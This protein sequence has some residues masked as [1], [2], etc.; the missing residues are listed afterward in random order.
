MNNIINK[1]VLVILLSFSIISCT[2][3]EETSDNGWP[4]E[5]TLGFAADDNLTDYN[6][7][8]G[9]LGDYI[10]DQLGLKKVHLKRSSEYAAVIEAMK[11]GKVDIA[12]LGGLSYILAHEKTG[13][14]AIVRRALTDTIDNFTSSVLLTHPNAKYKTIE[15]IKTNAGEL[16]L[17]FGDP[18]STSGHLFPRNYLNSVGI[19]PEKDF[20]EVIFTNSHTTSVFSIK[21]ESLDLAWTYRLAL[22]RLI[23]KGKLTENDVHIVYETKPY[24][25]AP[26]MVRKE[27][28]ED[29]KI[30]LQKAFLDLP[31]KHPEIWKVYVEGIYYYYP[32]EIRE[33]FVFVKSNDA[34]YDFLRELI[35][36]TK[37][38]E[39]ILK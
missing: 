31:K 17:G 10:G 9:I 2:T 20:K 18:A 27:L 15:E 38:F 6:R 16:S 5:I 3:K 8:R 22:N 35:R 4:T 11:S 36:N 13:A 12:I 30:A 1:S 29:F 26:I 23:K 25:T 39:D 28:P 19:N 32:K 7:F 24:I 33:K 37:G 21:N 34:E 14:E